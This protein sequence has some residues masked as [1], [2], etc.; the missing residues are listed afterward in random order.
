M[1]DI[2]EIKVKAGRG[3]DGA[4]TFRR[5]KFVPFGGPDGGDGGKGGDVIIQADPSVMNLWGF[6]KKQ[7]Y[8]GDN[9]GAGAAQKKHGRNGDPLILKVPEGT[10]VYEKNKDGLDD[11]LGDLEK[12]GEQVIVAHGGRG[13]LGNVH[14]ASSTN[15]TRAVRR[16]RRREGHC[17]G[18]ETNCRCRDYRLPECR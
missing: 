8:K 6:K 2:T 10:V 17:P 9:A 14:F 13:G 12:Q 1:F 16:S 4:I 15:Q 5:E 3:G 7:L 11:L 18:I